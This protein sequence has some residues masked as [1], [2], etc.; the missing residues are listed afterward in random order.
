MPTEGEGKMPEIQMPEAF[1]DVF[2]RYEPEVNNWVMHQPTSRP[3]KRFSCIRCRE[4]VTAARTGAVIGGT[5]EGVCLRC[6]TPEEQQVILMLPTA[7]DY[8]QASLEKVRQQSKGG[9]STQVKAKEDFHSTIRAMTSQPTAKPGAYKELGDEHYA[10]CPDCKKRVSKYS[11]NPSIL[12]PEKLLCGPCHGAENIKLQLMASTLR[13]E[14]QQP[15]R[16]P[17]EGEGENLSSMVCPRCEREST[18]GLSTGNLIGEGLAKLEGMLVCANC[19][20]AMKAEL[21]GGGA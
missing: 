4:V 7:W 15:K 10:V 6:C 21:E 13:Q 19:I 18:T 1:T 12:E 16:R 9:R 20:D 2:G 14:K 17:V 5:F 3:G 11:L 8:R